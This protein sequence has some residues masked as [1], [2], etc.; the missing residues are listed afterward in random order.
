MSS[1]R[2]QHPGIISPGNARWVHGGLHP[3][4][5]DDWCPLPE[6]D[7]ELRS[8]RSSD[9]NGL[10]Q[11]TSV[12]SAAIPII[13]LDFVDLLEMFEKDPGTGAVVLIGEIGGTAERSR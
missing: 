13:G 1:G 8:C 5:G 12:G 6:R 3:Q 7:I 10:G 11:S 2:S 9:K 4:G